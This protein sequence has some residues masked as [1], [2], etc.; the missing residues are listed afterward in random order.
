M[1]APLI[2]APNVGASNLTSPT[3]IYK[4]D[5]SG[6]LERLLSGVANSAAPALIRAG[7]DNLTKEDMRPLLENMG[8]DFG[9]YQDSI[10]PDMSKALIN[11]DLRR[12]D[13]LNQNA[14]NQARLDLMRDESKFK[15][16]QS[17]SDMQY[18]KD[19]EKNL[20]EMLRKSGVDYSG[21]KIPASSFNSLMRSI[22]EKDNQSIDT[23]SFLPNM[24][25]K[26]T[27]L[28]GDEIAKTPLPSKEPKGVNRSDP[29]VKRFSVL[30]NKVKNG[31]VSRDAAILAL[32]N[33]QGISAQEAAK[34]LK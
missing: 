24:N 32:M 3:P 25:K 30:R 28:P 7:M 23:S 21:D 27:I 1:A 26:Q 2:T 5:K 15:R 4:R 11:A 16:E 29:S 10:S 12:S 9:N 6:F 8:M 13:Q 22:G 31:E 19:M 14:Y 33:S 20:A 34:I 17:E 18:R